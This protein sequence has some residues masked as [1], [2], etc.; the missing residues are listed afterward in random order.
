M[1]RIQAFQCP[2]CGASLSYEGGPDPTVTCEYCGSD[3]IVPEEL[4]PPPQA[5]A[6][7]FASPFTLAPSLDL[8]QLSTDKLRELEE[9]VSSGR[10]I[11]AIKLYREL[12]DV[13][14]KE[15]KEAVEK[16]EAG[17]PVV[18]TRVSVSSTAASS[19]QPARKSSG[20]AS[21]IL[22]I[23]FIVCIGG[24]VAAM[25]LGA[26]F[27]LSGSYRQALDAARHNPAVVEALGEPVEASWWP[28]GGEISCGSSSCSANYEIPIH[29]SLSKGRIQVRSDSKGAGFLN[30]GTWILDAIVYLEAGST[31]PLT[32]PVPSPAPPKKP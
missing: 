25:V 26:P 10:K 29:G 28:I 11:Q 3:V 24:F 31:V 32:V 27:R 16:L 22:G 4:R 6:P 1:P 12:F 8:G 9:L 15:A 2:S 17:E 19:D 18:F 20:C 7:A 14:L 5:D 13:G 30:E 23:L 21:T